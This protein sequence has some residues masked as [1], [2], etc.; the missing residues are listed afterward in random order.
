MRFTIMDEYKY[1][2]AHNTIWFIIL[3]SIHIFVTAMY[4]HMK[5]HVMCNV[6]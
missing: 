1:V 6:K 5:G 4:T 2:F 3:I